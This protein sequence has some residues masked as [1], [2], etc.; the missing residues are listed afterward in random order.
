MTKGYGP[1]TVSRATLTQPGVVNVTKSEVHDSGPP[2]PDTDRLL[3]SF[4]PELYV[5]NWLKG[6]Q[7]MQTVSQ[8]EIIIAWL[9]RRP[10]GIKPSG[11]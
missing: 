11:Q 10:E 7:L 5:T 4:F 8:L 1:V 2:L 9:L 3:H 6:P